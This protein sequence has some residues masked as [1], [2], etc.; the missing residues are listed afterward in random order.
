MRATIRCYRKF[1]ERG[2]PWYFATRD[3]AGPDADQIRILRMSKRNYIYALNAD[4]FQFERTNWDPD[5]V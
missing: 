2:V 1:D 5:L 3:E 4:S